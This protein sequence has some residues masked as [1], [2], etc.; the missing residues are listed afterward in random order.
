MTIIDILPLRVLIGLVPILVLL[1][2]L[3][4][5]IDKR[6]NKKPQVQTTEPF[7]NKP[8]E[9]H[10]TAR[11]E[12]ENLQKMLSPEAIEVLRVIAATEQPFD[13]NRL[14]ATINK[15]ALSETFGMSHQ[16]TKYLL[17]LLGRAGTLELNEGIC[18]ITHEG[19]NLLNK[20][21][22]MP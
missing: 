13:N 19:R 2:I 22:K 17:E 21:K 20:A 18:G 3:R 7:K 16:K 8:K 10:A 9:L 6:T 1:A 15:A 12:R 14:Q 11:R 5:S 4:N